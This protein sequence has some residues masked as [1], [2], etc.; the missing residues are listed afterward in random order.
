MATSIPCIPT[1][2]PLVSS[3]ISDITCDQLVDLFWF[4][5][6]GASHNR[7]KKA[8]QIPHVKDTRDSSQNIKRGL[9]APALSERQG[10]Q[11]S[12]NIDIDQPNGSSSALK[13]LRRV[14]DTF[15]EN[16][17]GLLSLA[18]LSRSFEKLGLESSNV[19]CLLRNMPASNGQ[20]GAVSHDDFVLLYQGS[21]SCKQDT[22]NTNG[23]AER[24]MDCSRDDAQ[25]ELIWDAFNVFDKDKDGFISPS[26]LQSVLCNLG[27]G[28]AKEIDAC[29]EMI[30][31][32]DRD[33]NGQVDFEEFKDMLDS[34]IK[35][36]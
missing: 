3:G 8:H 19:H 29:I 5:G 22:S 21:S 12:V 14:F 18:E 16:K 36:S 35:L 25:E 24:P 17:D 32:Y 15:D 20:E 6:A 31:G 33:G 1:P 26:E 9:H 27:F 11:P 7:V 10:H 28:A 23:N 4:Y 34:A 2:S 30:R 13:W